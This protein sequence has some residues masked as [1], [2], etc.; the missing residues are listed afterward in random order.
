MMEDPP[1]FLA[2]LNIAEALCDLDDPRI[3]DFINELDRI[4]TIAELSPGYVWRL[5]DK[6]GNSATLGWE[7]NRRMIVTMSVWKRPEDLENF[8]FGTAH[9]EFYR[10]RDAW[11][12]AMKSHHFIMWWVHAGHIP[13]LAEAR[14]KLAHFEAYGPTPIAFGWN[15]LLS[16][17]SL[18][19]QAYYAQTIV[20][21]PSVAPI[22]VL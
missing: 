1:V 2:Q 14:E 10:R 5:K 11:F 13:D 12:A 6:N 21:Q 17:D 15:K 19:R 18:R 4:N 8:V 9:R 16:E 20:R 3:A 7:G 22:E